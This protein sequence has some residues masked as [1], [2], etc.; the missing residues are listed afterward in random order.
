MR[1]IM[2]PK[3]RPFAGEDDFWRLRAFL[4]EVMLTNERQERSWHV[5]R[6]DYWR[7][8]VIDNCGEPPMQG[9]TFLWET[10]DGQMVAA[11]NP[12][13]A[14]DAHFQVHPAWD[15]PE[16][17]A[18]MLDV[19]EQHLA[20]ATPDG[21]CRLTAWVDSRDEARRQLLMQHGYT[22]GNGPEYKHRCV[23]DGPLPNGRA[24]EGY[25]VRALGD[26]S[27]LPARSWASWQGF[28]PDEPAERYQG[29]E[30][31]RNIQRMPLYRR[32][33]DIVATTPDGE[34]A[35]FCTLWYDDATR[36]AYFEPVATV[37]AH[38]RRGL[39]K[40]VMTEALRRLQRMGGVV[41]FVGGYSPE[42][43]ALYSS[44][45]VQYATL[46]CWIKEW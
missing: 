38:Q 5:A 23:L 46:E 35:A 42:A 13:G 24:P 22:Q 10:A 21:K 44:M 30:W 26:E 9:H 32:D 4:R 2:Q 18:E 3:M 40:A 28:H 25:E 29:W 43:R 37:R 6:L 34:V 7:W 19:A 27:E 36:S 8:H 11:L 39:G 15:M 14:G 17:Q 45:G 1:N 33:L 41:A 12:E 31:Y 16:L 20:A